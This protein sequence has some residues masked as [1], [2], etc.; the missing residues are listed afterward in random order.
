M[1]SVSNIKHQFLET[2]NDLSGEQIFIEDGGGIDK[3]TLGIF[4]KMLV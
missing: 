2:K 4:V 3:K 1:S